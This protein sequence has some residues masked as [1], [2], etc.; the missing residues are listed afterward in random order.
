MHA[1]FHMRRGIR[2]ALGAVPRDVLLLVVRQGAT[3]ALGGVIMGA[4][5]A[6]ATTRWMR[7][8]LFHVDPLDP[9]TFGSVA[10]L[11]AM[12]AIGASWIPARRASRVSPVVAMRN[13]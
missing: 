7:S 2:I 9:V 4:A 1:A 3:L 5:A 13:E 11:L 10:L 8:M 12:V 6:V